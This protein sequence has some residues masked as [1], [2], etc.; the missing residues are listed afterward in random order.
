MMAAGS[1]AAPAPAMTTSATWSKRIGPGLSPPRSWPEAAV[2]PTPRA[3]L[4]LRKSL[5]LTA[6]LFLC[7]PLF[8]RRRWTPFTRRRNDSLDTQ[9]GHHIAVV[10]VVMRDGQGQDGQDGP[11]AS[12]H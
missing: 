8:R 1:P 11:R 6:G 3:V 9:I 4:F 7:M 10:L 2:A 12:F 5:R